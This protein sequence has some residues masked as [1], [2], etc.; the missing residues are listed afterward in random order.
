MR[1]ITINPQRG[2]QTLQL[3]RQGENQ[4][5]AVVFDVSGWATDYGDG[6]AE[7]L[8]KRSG[9]TA[10]YPVAL[11]V[12]GQTVR[13][14]VSNADTAVVGYGSAE[15]RW[16]AGE[17]LAKSAEYTTCVR[18]A[19]DDGEI[20]NPPDPSEDW[21][22]QVLA[23]IDAAAPSASVAKVGGVTTIT[24][25]DKDGTTTASVSDGATG[26]TGATGP[27]GP[28]G[29]TGDTGPRGPKG[30]KGNTG[31]QGPQGETGPAGADGRTPVRGVDYY[32]TADQAAIVQDVLA[33]LP[34]WTGGSY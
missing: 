31:A 17:T 11:T 15:L 2:V 30:D 24:V 22:Q 28:K 25:T 32:T 13:W 33:A 21:L 6:T 29:D 12:D 3:G 7:L 18:K 14:T 10:P 19:L 4:A 1:E 8:C 20:V 23:S 34:T 26:A 16:Y 27:Q 5:L 9:D